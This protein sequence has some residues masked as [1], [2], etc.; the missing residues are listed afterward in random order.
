MSTNINV[1]VDSGGLSERAKQQ[2]LAARQAQLEKERTIN[3]SAEALDKRVAAQAAKG[4][5]LNGQPLYTAGLKQ[6][7]LERRPAA[8]RTVGKDFLLLKPSQGIDLATYTTPTEKNKGW[9]KFFTQSPSA[10]PVMLIEPTGG[11][12]NSTAFIINR[13]QTQFS[14][15]IARHPS[16]ENIPYYSTQIENATLEFFIYFGNTLPLPAP[17]QFAGT[18]QHRFFWRFGSLGFLELDMSSA[19]YRADGG[20]YEMV[21][22][23]SARQN[24]TTAYIYAAADVFT[25]EPQN[26]DPAAYRLIA[27]WDQAPFQGQAW[28]HVALVKNQRNLAL[29]IN[30]A[31]YS[32]TALNFDYIELRPVNVP[33]GQFD[34]TTFDAQ[35]ISQGAGA[36][37]GSKIHGLRFTPK[38]LYTAPFTPPL[39]L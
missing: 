15:I 2:Q 9:P 34:F 29:Y 16:T 23:A 30:G 22:Y 36:S 25:T 1:T 17:Q 33:L 24:N 38:A 4:L 27:P 12:N 14:R 31:L 32:Q 7:Q 28:Y 13:A 19:N 20:F 10:Y 5:S 37:L 3:L 8:T 39:N 35:I 6:P 18:N 11:P 21:L 26:Y